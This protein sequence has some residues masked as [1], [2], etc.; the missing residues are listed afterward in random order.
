MNSD[1]NKQLFNMHSIIIAAAQKM[2]FLSSMSLF[3][4][5]GHL[6]ALL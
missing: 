6:S 4:Q 1:I 2:V 3:H 5:N